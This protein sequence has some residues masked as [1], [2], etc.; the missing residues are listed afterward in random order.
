[1][2]QPRQDYSASM[3]LRRNQLGQRARRKREAEA[4]QLPGLYVINE[5][6]TSEDGEPPALP[7]GGVQP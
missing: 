1:M 6:L 3:R 7:A 5:E 2:E 4:K